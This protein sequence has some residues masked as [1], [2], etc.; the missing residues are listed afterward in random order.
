MP[1]YEYV[2]NKCGLE[3]EVIQ[4]FS[5]KPLARCEKCGGR[6]RKLVSQSAFH[7]KGNGW[8]VT[9]YAS[10]HPGSKPKDASENS[11]TGS[12]P[13]ADAS[14]SG[15]SNDTAAKASKPKSTKS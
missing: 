4:S 1:I 5:D 15:K 6:V 2:C 13:A 10:R 8:Y 14:A 11:E 9:D 7:L 3:F 12:K